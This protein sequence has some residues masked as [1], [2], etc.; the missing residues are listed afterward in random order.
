LFLLIAIHSRHSQ[1]NSFKLLE[2][3]PDDTFAVTIDFPSTEWGGAS[4]SHDA[5]QK[6]YVE[7]CPPEMIGSAIRG[8]S[9]L[10]NR[11]ALIKA[12]SGKF[13]FTPFEGRID[14]V[15]ID[16][17]HAYEAV[18]RD[19]E[20]A[21]KLVSPGGIILIDDVHKPFRLEG[22][23]LAVLEQTYKQGKTF[24]FTNHSNGPQG[25]LAFYLNTPNT[26]KEST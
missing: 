24:Y 18:A 10:E 25:P 12:D 16:G 15:V 6:S 3:S 7:N 14:V 2:A 20:S 26:R 13:D 11:V 21:M 17:N 4:Y 8:D 5:N 19:L 1:C 23:T 9:E 22:V